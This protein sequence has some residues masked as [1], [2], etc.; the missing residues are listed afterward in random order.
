VLILI[1]TQQAG[2]M[3]LLDESQANLILQDLSVEYI[4]TL[5]D[6]LLEV[7]MDVR[8]A[9]SIP[10]LL[11]LK[12]LQLQPTV[13]EQKTQPTIFDVLKTNKNPVPSPVM[14]K[15]VAETGEGIYIDDVNMIK[16]M[17]TGD[18]DAKNDV[19]EAWKKIDNFM[20][21][22]TFAALASILKDAKPY[23][24][25]K[26]ILA[27]EVDQVSV[28]NKLNLVANQKSIQDIVRNVSGFSGLVYCLN[29]QECVKLKKLFM[30]L[31]Q[32]NKLPSKQDTPPTVKNW[33]FQ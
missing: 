14:T 11:Q 22:P 26:N 32:L 7:Q 31:A 33:S 4:P 13:V 3:H 25:S 21:Q 24:L 2:L 8:N 17:V 15:D 6:A 5:A 19:I 1:K 27:I 30:D 10:G 28:A 18:K 23:V 20:F 9:Q 12:L 29:R 16:V